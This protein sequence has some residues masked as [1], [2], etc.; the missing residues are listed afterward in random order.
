[1]SIIP[2]LLATIL[3]TNLYM[4]VS[5][6]RTQAVNYGQFI[7]ILETK[8]IDSVVLTMNSTV[9]DITG[10]YR[11]KDVE[12]TFVASVPNTQQQNDDLM[13]LLT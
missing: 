5:S 1:M 9:I 10:V 8:K 4:F 12:Y 13:A 11:E 6:S 7:E 3:I 2:Y